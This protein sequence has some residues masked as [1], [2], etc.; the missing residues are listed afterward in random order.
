MSL[1]VSPCIDSQKDFQVV[2]FTLLP[3]IRLEVYFPRIRHILIFGSLQ[4]TLSIILRWKYTMIG[5]V[6]V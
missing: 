2:K 5:Q 4:G 3:M 1:E 6:L